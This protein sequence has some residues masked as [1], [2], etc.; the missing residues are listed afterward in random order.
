MRDLEPKDWDIATN[1][2]PKEIQ[3][4]FPRSFY[5]NK[6]FTVK[7]ATESTDP[8]LKEIEITTFRSEAKYTDRRHPDEIK[9]AKTIEEDLSRR[10]FTVNAMAMK[11]TVEQSAKNIK[12]VN[13]K[14][15]DL[16]KGKEDL[17]IRLLGQ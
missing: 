9:P 3:Q 6:F 15:I 16:F 1:A 17:K 2:T 8:R 5:D 14:I 12:V 11:L 7:V 13:Y 10:D 4:L